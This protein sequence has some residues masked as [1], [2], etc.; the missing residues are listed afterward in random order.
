MLKA[1]S[2]SGRIANFPAIGLAN[3]LVDTLTIPDAVIVTADPGVVLT[4][5]TI[6]TD[7]LYATGNAFV[8]IEGVNML[9]WFC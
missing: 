7:V 3:Y 8:Y 6:D 5:G 1:A 9:T 2:A 4:A